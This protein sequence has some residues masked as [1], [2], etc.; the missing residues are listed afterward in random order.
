MNRTFY[1]VLA[2]IFW[3][4]AG[5]CCFAGVNW[6]LNTYL[7]PP[8][9]VTVRGTIEYQGSFDP[10]ASAVPPN[11]YFVQS[12]AAGRFYLEAASVKPYQGSF[13]QAVGTL[14]TICGPDGYPCYPK[15]EPKSVLPLPPPK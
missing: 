4:A 5:L 8:D 14:S 11:G 13:I 2:A 6:L 7:N 9:E 1:T 3:F 10:T 15:L 12:T